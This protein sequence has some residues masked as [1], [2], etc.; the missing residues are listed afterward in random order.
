MS[1]NDITNSNVEVEDGEDRM[2]EP[3]TS[4]CFYNS[5][6]ALDLC[7]YHTFNM[8]MELRYITR[9][10]LY[11]TLDD[12]NIHDIVKAWDEHADIR[13]TLKMRYKRKS[14]EEKA[15]SGPWYD[16]TVLCHGHIEY[17]DTSHVT[18]MSKLFSQLTAFDEDISR[19]DVSNVTDMSHMFDRCKHFNQSLNSWDVSNVIDM[20]GM[21]SEA[22]IFNQ[23]LDQWNVSSVTTMENMFSCAKEF[24]QSLNGWN[25]SNV[26]KF[27]GIFARAIKFNQPLD[28]WQISQADEIH[29]MFMVCKHFNQPLNHWRIN[30]N[31]KDFRFMFYLCQSFNQ[32][33]SNWD[34]SNGEDF[35]S[36]F[37]GAMMFNQ[38]LDSWKITNAKNMRR[39]FTKAEAFNQPLHEYTWNVS[40]VWNMEYFLRSASSYSYDPQLILPA[41][42]LTE[43]RLWDKDINSLSTN[44]SESSAINEML[45]R[46]RLVNIFGM[47][48]RIGMSSASSPKV[49]NIPNDN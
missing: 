7:L 32:P 25:V 3:T 30:P 17:W 23:P 27:K 12:S 8:P 46:E 40:N 6:F 47:F 14:A 4:S 42:G 11:F 37:C 24:N 29:A 36:M 15:R 21:F 44:M 48:L 10:Y 9:C 22:L 41:W 31:V 2:N 33:L 1:V 5:N 39:M 16:D 28:S 43:D 35:Q 38:P 13:H 26:T 49:A 20:Q 45:Q 19:W 18:N 34:V